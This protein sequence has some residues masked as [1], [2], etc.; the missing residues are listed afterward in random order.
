MKGRDISLDA[1]AGLFIIYMIMGHAF[2]WANAVDDDFYV[3][4]NYFLYMFMAWFF[5]KSGMFHKTG[6]PIKACV[7][8][9]SKKLLTPWI[10][11]GIVGECVCWINLFLNNKLTLKRMIISPIRQIIY[12]G[13][14]D[15]NLP[16]WFLLTLFLVKIITTIASKTIIR[17]Y[18]LIA[19]CII[20]SC[21]CGGYRPTFEFLKFF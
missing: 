13:S 12:Q 19:I 17:Q 18:C 7:I 9:Y 4:C 21:V 6:M 10:V 11:Y 5:F 16:L 14:V 3:A 2:Q 8:K 20:I 15:G 1:V